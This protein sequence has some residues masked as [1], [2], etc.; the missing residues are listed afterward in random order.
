MTAFLQHWLTN[1]GLGWFDLKMLLERSLAFDS[2]ALHVA[3]GVVVQLLTAALLRSSVGRIGPWLAVLALELA[4]EAVDLWVEV[5]PDPAMQ[6]GE[7]L[8]DVLLTLALP[9][10]LLVVSRKWPDLLKQ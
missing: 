9:T 2:D 7:G 10:L 6:W 3:S 4:N 8:K 5:W 1:L